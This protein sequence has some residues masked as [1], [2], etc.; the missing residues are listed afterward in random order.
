MRWA[1]YQDGMYRY[2]CNH[3]EQP[4]PKQEFLDAVKTYRDRSDKYLVYV[5]YSKKDEAHQKVIYVGT[6]IQHP[7]SRWYYHSTHGKDLVFEEYCRFD[8][9]EDMLNKEFELI[10]RL[11]PSKN[12]I[13]HRKQNLNTP[14]TAEELERRKGDPQWCPQCLRSHVRPGYK[15]CWYCANGKR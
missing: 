5:G 4:L 15:G 13:T 8:N 7:M 12:V 6:T 9:S 1:E 11:H 10:Q 14:L 2:Y 3:T